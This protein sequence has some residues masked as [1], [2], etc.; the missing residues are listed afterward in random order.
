MR[1]VSITVVLVLGLMGALAALAVGARNPSPNPHFVGTP[2]CTES[3]SGTAN[4]TV[5]CSGKVAGLGSA[6]V[7]VRVDA[8][9]T[10][11]CTNRGQNQPPG[12]TRSAGQQF[13]PT[14]RRGQITF[15]VTTSPVGNP[16]PD[17]M[18]AS[19]SFTSATITVEQPPGTAVLST[20][21]GV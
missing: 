1:R 16:C 7:L 6:P 10:T 9:G 12:Q 8:V 11:V 18:T 21:I 20:T 14:V 17:R 15:S 5:T 2:T 4:A 3:N 19:T 13:F